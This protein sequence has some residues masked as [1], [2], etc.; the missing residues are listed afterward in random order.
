MADTLGQDKNG[1]KIGEIV[2]SPGEQSSLSKSSLPSRHPDRRWEA[3]GCHGGTPKVRFKYN[4][5][6]VIFILLQKII[7]VSW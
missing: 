5:N 7:Y 1:E 6:F 2:T 3:F 4:N